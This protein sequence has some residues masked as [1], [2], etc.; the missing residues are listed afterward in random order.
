[1]TDTVSI[2]KKAYAAVMLQL[3]NAYPYEACGVLLSNKNNGVIESVGSLDNT[4]AAEKRASH[5]MIDPLML[6]KLETE[7]EKNDMEVAGFYHSHPDK[8]AIP[9]KEDMQ[10][11]IPGML[12]M[13]VSTLRYGVGEIKGYIKNDPDGKASGVSIWEV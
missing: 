9:S 7:A 11:M 3:K 12:Y 5:Y 1:M 4:A 10:Y 6:Y 8:A 2:S 13:I